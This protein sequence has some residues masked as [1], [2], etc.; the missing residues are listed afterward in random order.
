MALLL[1]TND[2]VRVGRRVPP[3]KRIQGMLYSLVLM[4]WKITEGEKKV[5][6]PCD[7]SNRLDHIM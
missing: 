1:T 3:E 4:S 5:S 2:C 6:T 7:A